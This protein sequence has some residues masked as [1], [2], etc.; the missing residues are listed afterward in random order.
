M[1]R[2]TTDLVSG[3][4]YGFFT[5]GDLFTPRQLVALTTF[6]D[7]V[8]EARE[9]IRLDALAAGLSD[10]NTP[11]AQNGNGASAYAEAVS[12]YLA[13]AINKL[14]DRGSTIC[15]WFTERDSTRNTFARQSIP[16]TWDY[17]ELN[18]LL[19]GTGSFAGAIEWTAESLEG[20]CGHTT[21]SGR[22]TQADAQTQRISAGKVISTDPPYYDNIGYAD[23]SDF[24]YV[25]L[26]RSLKPVFPELFGT[27]VVPK[28]DE[29]VATPYRHGSRAAAEKFFLDGMT[30]AMANLAKQS[31][32]EFPVT[33][34]YAF[35][36]S[37]TDTGGTSN[38]GWAT[39]LEA[40]IRAG[41]QITGTWPMRSELSNR[42]IASG[43]N[44][45]ASSIVLVCRRRGAG[46]GSISRRDFLRELNATLPE[47]LAAMTGG[48]GG[49]ELPPAIGAG[50]EEEASHSQIAPVDLEQAIIGPGMAVFSKYARVE[51]NEGRAMGV[52]EALA[53]I[54]QAKDA[55]LSEHEGDYDRETRWA[56]AWFAQ[57]GFDAAGYG[58][59]E[60]LANAK[61]IAVP[62][63]VES[64]IVESGGGR[65]R[66]LRPAELP[67]DW[68]PETDGRPTV[69]E[70]THHLVRLWHVENAGEEK[71]AALLRRLGDRAGDAR[72]LAYRLFNL[73]ERSGRGADAQGYNA[74]AAGWGVLAARAAE[75][76]A[77][78]REQGEMF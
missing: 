43:T 6:S 45:L 58:E 59:A 63:L 10:D 71:T 15:T 4:G 34:Y 66:L 48:I 42:M 2:D 41:F 16:M 18:M 5:W 23:L 13:F 76:P 50:E 68:S 51:D 62:A 20:A 3:R 33:I 61:A 11:L 24:F 1:N 70:M 77:A 54:I 75:T 49:A 28:T 52:A 74:L 14:A 64:G 36:Q 47:A 69:W 22:A 67:G 57:H 39:F 26:R 56:L 17:A 29:L 46:A 44:A 78:K 72:A 55:M 37:E 32:P 21:I 31:H 30:G 65:A 9:L 73:A 40:V 7:L 60:T 8:G 12:V 35:K 38:T 25:W 19:D 27:L 53:L